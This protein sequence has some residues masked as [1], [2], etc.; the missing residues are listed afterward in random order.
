M[1]LSGAM[2]PANP[3]PT[4]WKWTMGAYSPFSWSYLAQRRQPWPSWRTLWISPNLQTP[5]CLF[6][7]P[8]FASAPQQLII[9]DHN[10]PYKNWIHFTLPVQ[11][12][13]ITDNQCCLHFL[14]DDTVKL[15]LLKEMINAFQWQLDWLTTALKGF[16]S[17]IMV[18]EIWKRKLKCKIV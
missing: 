8:I 16:L 17:V 12:S 13:R 5:S 14:K 6:V 4:L 15:R 18:L 3:N 10:S 2:G 1:Y 7:S 11:F 9:N